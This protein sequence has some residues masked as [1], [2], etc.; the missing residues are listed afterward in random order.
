MTG[1]DDLLREFLLESVENLDR[2]DQ[3]FVAL[4]REPDDRERLGAIFRTIHTIKGTSGFFD[5]SRLESL[6]H[7]G[8]TLLSRLRDGELA[9][10]G[11]M[12]SALL[13]TVDA[14]RGMLASIEADGSE[15]SLDIAPL[16][17][18]LARLGAQT[19]LPPR[20][21]SGPAGAADSRASAAAPASSERA[22]PRGA[23]IADTTV[24]VDVGLL[25]DVMNMVGELVLARN[26]IVQLGHQV[27]DPSFVKA[28][29]RLDLL[30]TELQAGIMKTRMQP[31]G[32]VWNKLPRVVRDLAHAR[33]K[34]V[35]VELDGADTE[36]D[37][38]IL[39]ALKDPL[40]HLVRN[41]VDHGVETP[42]QR[43][44]AGKP[45]RGRL[46]LKAF[47]ESGQVNIEVSDDGAGLDVAR[48]R[49][50]AVERGLVTAE[51]A[52]QLSEREAMRLVFE[53]GVSTA[54]RV[55]SVSGRGVGM[56]VVRTNIEKIGGAVDVASALGRGTVLKI[57][58]PLTL[59][60]VPAL[61]VTARAERFAV[62]QVNLLEL[63]RLEG[64]QLRANV[65][66]VGGATL[67][68]L[69]GDLLPLVFL[70]RALELTG[71]DPEPSSKERVTVVVVQADD[72]RFGLVVDGIRDTEEIV[73]KPLGK[74]LEGIGVFAGATI[75][76][77]GRVALI[78]DVLGLARR[79]GVVSEARPRGVTDER[80]AAEIEP[81]APLLL[82]RVGEEG[83]MAIP[84]SLIARI[85]EI[86]RASVERTSGGEVVR[87]RGEILPLVDLSRFFGATSRS[88]GPL[89]VVV[90]ADPIAASGQGVGLVVEQ[91]LDIV[92][93]R[94]PARLRGTR[95]GVLATVVVRDEVAELLD[96]EGVVRMAE[97]RVEGAVA[98]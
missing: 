88:T 45:E 16:V 47:H 67:C 72:R 28:S 37:R 52:A 8:E 9:L 82:C 59:A 87:R 84:L 57:K 41:A 61:I 50:R 76:G 65:E 68:R 74:E 30:T 96:V 71:A 49:A 3:D 4:E 81:Q 48:I 92:E 53:P 36:L 13:A 51:R 22:A 90:C 26:Q 20:A 75:M 83:R 31:I 44:A 34:R 73:V 62:P 70:D 19:R 17:A 14:V 33:G 35:D 7:A 63:V 93:E 58:I 10:D 80:G 91:V 1:D 77:D 46:F 43:R 79:A 66:E 64:E 85:E 27:T 11:A 94:S 21:P 12:T 40:T 24:R 29:Q 86:D 15:G 32:N 97:R 23:S 60:I 55:T 38:T 2:L 39:E 42:A 18:E 6:T 95:P 78:L 56:D 69:R 5:L 25:D 54:E 98:A 89:H